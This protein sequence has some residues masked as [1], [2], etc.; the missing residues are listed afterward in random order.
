MG[1][2]L[3]RKQAKKEGKSLKQEV[4]VEKNQLN[5]LLVITIVL[6]VIIAII[7]LLSAVFVTKELNWFDKEEKENPTLVDNTILASE[8]FRQKEETYYV[9]FYDYGNEDYETSS[10]VN[11]TLSE[12]IVYNVDTSSAL[13]NKY[14]S[15]ESNKKAKALADLKVKSPT[16]IK[17][18][19]EQIVEYYEGDEITEKLK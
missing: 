15:E 13:N 10:S 1:R 19:G 5:S 2:E 8:I 11:S 18:S 17:I 7:Y 4:S 6:V 3:R 16:V 14:I 9:Y 12:A